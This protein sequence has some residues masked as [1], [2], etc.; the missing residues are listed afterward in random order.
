MTLFSIA[1]LLV[2]IYFVAELFITEALASKIIRILA[3]VG[4]GILFV[5]SLKG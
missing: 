3:T 5:F 4:L 1:V 2:V